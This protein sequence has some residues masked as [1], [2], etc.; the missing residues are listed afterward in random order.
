MAMYKCDVEGCDKYFSSQAKL[1]RHKAR[2]HGAT[3]DDGAM[4]P[5]ATP[6]DAPGPGLTI[7]KPPP[8]ETGGYVCGDCGAAVSKGQEAC[9]GCGEPLHWEGIE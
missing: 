9:P 4:V 3:P 8:Q 2:V 6:G 1:K 5:A 7:K